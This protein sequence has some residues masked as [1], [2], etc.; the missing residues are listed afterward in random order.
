MAAAVILYMGYR[1]LEARPMAIAGPPD[2]LVAPFAAFSVHALL[3]W[4]ARAG[5]LYPEHVGRTVTDPA[6]PFWRT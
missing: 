3:Q 5:F 6:R 4:E 1:S 2:G